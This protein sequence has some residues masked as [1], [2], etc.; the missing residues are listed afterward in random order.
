MHTAAL[1]QHLGLKITNMLVLR[2]CIN[3]RHDEKH[4]MLL[5]MWLIEVC[6]TGRERQKKGGIMVKVAHIM[7]LFVSL[8]IL[9]KAGCLFVE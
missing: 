8:V 7:H 9:V 4:Q 1:L 5:I 6:K 3:V 2:C